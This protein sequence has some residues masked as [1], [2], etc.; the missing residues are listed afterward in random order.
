MAETVAASLGPARLGAILIAAFGGLALL[1]AAVGVYG[2]LAFSIA[3]RTRE[4][5]IRV[6]LGAD[7]G[8]VF[9]LVV[10]EGMTL[11]AIGMAIGLAGAAAGATWLG[12]FL[13][14]IGPRDPVAFA[15]APIVLAVVALLAC[16]MP[17]YRAMRV[18]PV[19]ALRHV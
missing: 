4:M 15:T 18:S 16:L 11:V 9:A 10:R 14:T 6:A 3:R 12:A 8:R 13:Y 7:A 5:G 19:V 2:V 17:A 1:L